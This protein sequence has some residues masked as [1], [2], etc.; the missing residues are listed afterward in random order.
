MSSRN[1]SPRE[2]SLAD[3]DKPRSSWLSFTLVGILALQLFIGLCLLLMQIATALVIGV[4]LLVLVGAAHYFIWGRWL[5][6]AIRQEVE[7]E[8]RQNEAHP[9]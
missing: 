3:A 7:E 5:G 1:T 6:D 8:E 2:E 9:R 4:A